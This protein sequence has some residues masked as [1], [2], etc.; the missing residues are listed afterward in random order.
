MDLLDVRLPR[1]VRAAAGPGGLRVRDR[2]GERAQRPHAAHRPRRPHRPAHRRRARLAPRARRR[3]RLPA[4]RGTPVARARGAPG[5]A[6]R[7]SRDLD[8]PVDR[9]RRLRLELPGPRR[10]AH[11]RGIVRPPLPREGQHGPAGRGPRLRARPLPGQLDTPQAAPGRCGRHLLLRR[12]RRPLPAPH[13]RGHPH[14]VLLR[15]RLRTRAALGARGRLH[16]RG[17]ARALR[18]VQRLPRVEVPLDAAR[19]ADR[20]TRLAAPAERRRVHAACG[21]DRGLGVRALP[22]HRAAGVRHQR[23]RRAG[24]SARQRRSP[25]D[26]AHEPSYPRTTR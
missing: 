25:P 11:R 26:G 17:R 7:R 23:R 18:R 19:A 14:G 6:L 9:A 21:G 1:A 4:A 20:A 10:A 24:A 22:A 3:R 13:R 16:A 5:W 8:R 12:L 2:Q 15:D